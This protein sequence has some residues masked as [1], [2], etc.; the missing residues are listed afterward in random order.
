MFVLSTRDASLHVYLSESSLVLTYK[1]IGTPS[2]VNLCKCQSYLTY[3]SCLYFSGRI[4]YILINL[5]P[6]LVFRE[7]DIS[8]LME[9]M[10]HP[11]WNATPYDPIWH[12]NMQ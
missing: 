9:K 6:A 3:Y 12:M 11:T 5:N 4:L 2:S 7:Y 8:F 1:I 10:F